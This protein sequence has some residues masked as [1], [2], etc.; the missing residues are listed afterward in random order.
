MLT[1][2]IWKDLGVTDNTLSEQEQ[3]FLDENGYLSL[4][5]LL[6]T[7]QRQAIVTRVDELLSEEGENAGFELFDSPHIKHPKEL[8]SDRLAN[9]ANKGE[10][11]DIFYTHPKVLAAVR[12]VLGG[13]VKLSSLNY[14]AALPGFGLQKLHVDWKEPVS[15]GDY[16]VCNSIWLLDDFSPANGATRLVPGSHLWGKVPADLM[17]NPEDAHPQEIILEE[18]AGT[19]VIFNSHTWH[20][21]TTN[22]TAT[23]RRAIHSYFCR[24]DQ[25]QQLDHQRYINAETR[26][27]ISPS[28]RALLAV[29]QVN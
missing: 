14:R 20:G 21:G 9:L 24:G 15:K 12:R 22:K 29:D 8:G 10:V 28:M 3:K 27:R 26:R 2:S 18:P 23:P 11:F 13:D 6:D 17:E 1:K 4:G 16:K 25:P 19:V 5:I 7:Q